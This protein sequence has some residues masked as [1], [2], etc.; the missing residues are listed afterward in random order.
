MS[1]IETLTALAEPNRLEIVE[2]LRTGPRSVNEIVDALHMRQPQV[3]KH[4]RVL[5]AAGLVSVRPRAQ[6]RIYT[7][8]EPPFA[9]LT[10][11]IDRFTSLWNDRLDV[12]ADVA[13]SEADAARKVPVGTR[14]AA[15]TERRGAGEN[16]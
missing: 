7:L 15:K 9:E 8:S 5:S 11:W 13:R 4:L 1:M 3:S 12:L 16:A 14:A 6:M 2:L 10:S